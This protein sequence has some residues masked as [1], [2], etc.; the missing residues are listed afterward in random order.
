M[1]LRV[2]LVDH[3]DQHADLRRLAEQLPR[4]WA[5]LHGLR[6]E[7]LLEDA[8][9]GGIDAVFTSADPGAMD[10][11]TLL[12]R[13]QRAHPEALRVLVLP[14]GFDARRS[15]RLAAEP[16]VQ[17]VIAAPFEPTAVRAAM[18]RVLTV[19]GLLRDPALRAELGQVERLPASPSA[20]LSLRMVM[21]D[22]G[23][24]LDDA[25]QVLRRDPVLAARVLRTANSALYARGRPILDL[26]VA[27]Q[28]LGLQ[29]L[30]QLV[31]ASEV[32]SRVGEGDD[33]AAQRSALLASTLAMR[34]AA[35][36]RDAGLAGSA[37]LLADLGKQLPGS[38][39][40]APPH[41]GELWQASPRVALLGAGL[42]AMWGLPMEMVEAVAFH[43]APGRLPGRGLDVVGATHIA[44]AL[45]GA[46]PMDERWVESAGIAPR[47]AAWR[48]LA[49]K[50]QADAD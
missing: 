16:A 47:V 1:S 17:Q 6:P 8:E 10:G 45:V 32:F 44:R 48:D 50:L 36:P 7:Q 4:D 12:Q 19:R 37:A 34:I 42:M 9:F 21:A 49:Q 29:T 31:L 5:V 25:V 2:A 30:V 23:A 26:G 27:T 11:A 41:P 28:R 3:P 46:V 22:D 14:P 39:L 35:S 13:V 24:D 43:H 38:L 15:E 33:S 20:Y 40:N 18:R